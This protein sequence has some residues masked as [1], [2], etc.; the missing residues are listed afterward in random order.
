MKQIIDNIRKEVSKKRL[1]DLVK[2]VSSYHRI[3]ASTGFRDAANYV[4]KAINDLGIEAKVYLLRQMKIN[5]ICKN[6]YFKNG[7]ARMRG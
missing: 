1:Y 4:C 2:G 3:Q 6:A 7:I 5:G